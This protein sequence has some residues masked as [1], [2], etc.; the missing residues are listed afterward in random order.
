MG[1]EQST[2]RSPSGVNAHQPTQARYANIIWTSANHLLAFMGFASTKKMALD[3][4]ANQ[5]CNRQQF[6]YANKKKSLL[7]AFLVTCATSNTTNATRILVWME[8]NA[9]TIL[10]VTHVNAAADI[11]ANDATSKWVTVNNRDDGLSINAFNFRSIFAPT[12]LAKMA[13]GASIMATSIR[14]FVQV[15]EIITFPIATKF[16]ER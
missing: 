2:H 13:I 3:A 14:V 12:I 8:A 11:K 7:Q 16:R 15:R 5:V 9:S 6:H 1:I 10:A 4:S